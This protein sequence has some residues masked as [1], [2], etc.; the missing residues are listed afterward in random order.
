[1]RQPARQRS[2]AAPLAILL[3]LGVVLAIAPGRE[4]DASSDAE[5]ALA[6][7]ELASL[8]VRV[9]PRVARR[10]ERIRGL[11][12]ERLPEAEVVESEFLTRLERRER[13][14]T[15]GE[16][17]LAADEAAVS[18]VGL[19]GE[20][21]RLRDALGAS[22]E[23]AVAAY[24]TRRDRLYVVADAIAPNG[25]LVEFVLAHELTHALEDAHF[26]LAEATAR[27]S[28]DAALARLALNE[29]TATS[30][31]VSYA[32]GHLSASELLLALDPLD[33][34]T[35]EVPEFVVEQLEWAYLGGMEFIEGLRAV[36]G[37]W[38]L[39][40]HALGARPPASTEQVLHP[41]K[42]IADERPRPLT[43]PGGALRKAGWTLADAGDAGELSTRQLLA[44]G[45]ADELAE[46][47]A[48]GWDGDRY[49]L[50]RRR[51]A[52]SE[53][54]PGCRSDLV[55]VLRWGWDSRRD[56]A[57]FHCAAVDYL[58]AGLGGERQSGTSWELEDAA[59]ALRTDGTTSTLA[60]APHAGLATRVVEGSER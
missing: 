37:G 55:L 7:D 31:M 27:L 22:A 33:T 48:A 3:A 25:A 20:D 9:T 59:A 45:A 51:I 17:A 14:R 38:K 21:E 40:D 5:E 54:A 32:R 1:V 47:A 53:C 56:A 24:D 44:L 29:G 46:E 8:S 15:D 2:W 34:G 43:I 11:E 60:I 49:E 19:L 58:E 50:W 12:F 42:Y 18:M 26:G 52:P 4:R 16:R 13:R 28:D 10:L 36:A 39:V 23:L 30:T 6:P 41:E 35:G 57:E